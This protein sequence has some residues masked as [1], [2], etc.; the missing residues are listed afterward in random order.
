MDKGIRC[1]ALVHLLWLFLALRG[2]YPYLCGYLLCS[3]WIELLGLS[4]PW[5]TSRDYTR[6]TLAENSGNCLSRME[7]W[8]RLSFMPIWPSPKDAGEDN[9]ISLSGRATVERVCSYNQQNFL[10]AC[11]CCH[12]LVRWVEVC[13]TFININKIETFVNYELTSASLAVRLLSRSY[14]SLTPAARARQVGHKP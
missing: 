13:L 10:V 4:S 5:D 6:N 8:R 11:V 7:G 1:L 2:H 14:I 12:R 3:V 9:G